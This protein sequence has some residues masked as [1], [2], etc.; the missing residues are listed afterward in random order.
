MDYGHLLCKSGIG[1]VRVCPSQIMRGSTA[2]AEAPSDGIFQESR[3]CTVVFLI[4]KQSETNQTL[5]RVLPLREGGSSPQLLIDNNLF[6][7]LIACANVYHSLSPGASNED[8][9]QN[10][11][12]SAALMAVLREQLRAQGVGNGAEEALT[13]D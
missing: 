12:T 8:V 3:R 1:N 11:V 4:F 9:F 2:A 13:V 7:R 5:G 10:S 6:S